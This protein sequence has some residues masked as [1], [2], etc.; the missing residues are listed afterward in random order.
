MS[1][2][3]LSKG[4]F[5]CIFY[6]GITCKGHTKKDKNVVTKLQRRD[7]NSDNEILVGNLIKKIKNYKRYFLPVI[8]NCSVNIR[9][10]DSHEVKKCDIISSEKNFVVM[11]IPFIKNKN[12]ISL[13]TER[14]TTNKQKLAFLLQTY[15]YLLNSIG[16]LSEN[17]IIHFDLK[18]DNILIDYN[19]H[20]PYIIDFGISVPIKMISKENIKDYFYTFA[21]E[22]YVWCLDIIFINYILNDAV[23]YLDIKSIEYIV[24]S[25]IEF[26][27]GLFIF[28]DE[29]KNLYRTACIKQ[30]SKFIHLDNNQI[31]DYYMKFYKTWDNYSLSIIYLKIVHNLLSVSNINNPHLISFV[32]IL[33]LNIHPDPEKRLSIQQTREKF[34]NFILKSGD[35]QLYKQFANSFNFKDHESIANLKQDIL[36]LNLTKNKYKKSNTIVIK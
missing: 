3:L 30:L 1:S 27:R 34:N 18:L 26:N 31:I 33:T 14:N 10:I 16:L 17:D 7:F 11:D 36:D 32:E 24:D 12:L 2:K 13:L 19:S 20:I 28:S 8:N 4:G 21:P 5:G 22:Y 35:M 9:N 15:I 6:P 29:F 25:Y 23:G